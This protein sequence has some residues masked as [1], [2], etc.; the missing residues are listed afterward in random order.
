MSVISPLLLV[1]ALGVELRGD[2][3]ADL[4]A[5]FFDRLEA[6]AVA[7]I[8]LGLAKEL[9]LRLVEIDL[10]PEGLRHIPRRVAEHLDLVGLGVLE[11]DR[12]RIA[13]TGRGEALARGV[14]PVARRL[15]TIR[16]RLDL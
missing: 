12:P 6:L 14:A 16:G 3:L 5:P 15:L 10:E 4:G 11:I 7:A 8:G 13:V 9:L 2:L 1:D